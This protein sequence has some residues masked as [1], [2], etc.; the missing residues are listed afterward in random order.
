MINFDKIFNKFT[1]ILSN[2][3]SDKPLWCFYNHA[4]Y[5]YYIEF[6]CICSKS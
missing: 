5:W 4:N 6:Y 1:K 3:C 2:L